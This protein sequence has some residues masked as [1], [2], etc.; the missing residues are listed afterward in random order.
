MLNFIRRWYLTI[1][2]LPGEY[3]SGAEVTC[4]AGGEMFTSVVILILCDYLL[5]FPLSLRPPFIDS[6][7]TLCRPSLFSN[8]CD[9]IGYVIWASKSDHA[10]DHDK[11]DKETSHHWYS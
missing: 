10:H 6:L 3:S 1:F 8:P 5:Y 4:G 2:V 11:R 9:R 7:I